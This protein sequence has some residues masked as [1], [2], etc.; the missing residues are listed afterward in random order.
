VVI[1]GEF[2]GNGLDFR[3]DLEPGFLDGVV[4]P[5]MDVKG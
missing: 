5:V 4:D 1:N 3:I 2:Q